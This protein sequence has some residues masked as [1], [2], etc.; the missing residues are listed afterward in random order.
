MIFSLQGP[1]SVEPGLIQETLWAG[2][3]LT[4][5]EDAENSDGVTGIKLLPTRHQI[6]PIY[7]YCAVIV[8]LVTP[9][10]V[11]HCHRCLWVKTLLLTALAAADMALPAGFWIPRLPLKSESRI[12]LPHVSPSAMIYRRQISHSFLLLWKGVP[13]KSCDHGVA[14]QAEHK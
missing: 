14:E 11:S 9:C 10:S 8:F 12:A 5:R 3:S 1:F 4:T 2:T 13:P 6:S 7:K